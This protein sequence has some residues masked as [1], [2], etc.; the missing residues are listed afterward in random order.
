MNTS[1]KSLSMLQDKNW[2]C[3]CERSFSNVAWQNSMIGTVFSE[4]HPCCSGGCWYFHKIPSLCLIVGQRWYGNRTGTW[5]TLQ[6]VPVPA[7]LMLS[8]P[9]L[10]LSTAVSSSTAPV[11][12]C[13]CRDTYSPV[14][15]PD[16]HFPVCGPKTSYSGVYS[17]R[18]LV[19]H[20]RMH[21]CTIINMHN[22]LYK[23]C[24]WLKYVGIYSYIHMS[25]PCEQGKKL[26]L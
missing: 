23:L 3:F 14:Y 15:C 2:W 22:A 24:K 20:A 21:A 17:I 18:I 10:P 1:D 12:W 7:T 11:F 19:L 16:P 4:E 13:T 5:T 25:M 9:Q 8:S 6:T 26:Y